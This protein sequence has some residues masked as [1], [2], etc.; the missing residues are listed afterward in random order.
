MPVRKFQSE[1]R[2]KV[3]NFDYLEDRR[4]R[5]LKISIELSAHQFN[6]V[7]IGR[8]LTPIFDRVTISQVLKLADNSLERF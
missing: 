7:K 8:W 2:V 5:T 4:K 6:E 1:F 3:G